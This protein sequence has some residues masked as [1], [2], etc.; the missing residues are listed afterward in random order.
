MTA[1]P[2]PPRIAL[3]GISGYGR[4]HLHLARECRDRGEVT[5]VAAAVINPIQEADNV[6]EL[7]AHGCAVYSDYE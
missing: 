2:K 5:I 4:I 3:I 7:R 6:A 1:G